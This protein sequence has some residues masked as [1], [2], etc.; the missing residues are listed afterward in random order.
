MVRTKLSRLF[1]VVAASA[2]VLALSACGSGGTAPAANSSAPSSSESPAATTVTTATS[3]P[4]SSPPAAPPVAQ[5]VDNGLCKAGDVQLSLGQGDAG[6][7]SVYR[8]LLIKNASA[9][10]CV[11]QGFPGVS[12]VAGADGHQVGKDAFR[13]GTKGN[14]VKL[15]PG[16][17][18]AADIQFVNV[19]NFDP[20]TCQPTPVKGLRI[21]L[22]QE[23]ASNFVASDGTGCASTKI[24]G[25]QLAVKTVH[26]A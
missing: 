22:P 9:K 8:P 15:N 11:V 17:T 24:P 16:Q 20:G 14:A 7:G 6:A 25:N 23:T 21:Y 1:P 26:P 5:P 4:S 12:Y 2:G 10:P 19:Q 18:A 13:E 3:S